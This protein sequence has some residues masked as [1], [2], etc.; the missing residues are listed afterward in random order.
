MHEMS[1]PTF[2]VKKKHT[3]ICC[4][5]NLPRVLCA[6]SISFETSPL[7]TLEMKCQ[8]EAIFLPSIKYH[9]FVICWFHIMQGQGQH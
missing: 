6:T 2:S 9:L 3:Q 8:S 4:L 1:T 5:L 7:D